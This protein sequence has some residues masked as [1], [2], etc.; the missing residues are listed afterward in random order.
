MEEAFEGMDLR[1][2]IDNI[3]GMGA[4][5]KEHDRK[6]AEVFLR[7]KEKGLKFNTDKRIFDTASIPYFGHILTEEG[8]KPDLNK[9][10]L[11]KKYQPQK[12]KRSY[13]YYWECITTYPDT[14]LI[15]PHQTS[16]FEI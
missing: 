15:C 16:H 9:L 11:Y 4:T 5:N 3:T 12:A 7:A 6:L 10:E 2:I 8:I 1:L 14:Y 13:V